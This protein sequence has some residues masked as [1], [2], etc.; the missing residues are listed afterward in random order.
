MRT[1]LYGFVCCGIGLLWAWGAEAQTDSAAANNAAGRPAAQQTAQQQRT[2]QQI[3]LL[4][5]NAIQQLDQIV[6]GE[7]PEGSEIAAGLRTVV[8]MFSR[9]ELEPARSKLDEL[10]AANPTIPPAGLLWSALLLAFNQFDAAY[11]E[12][13]KT[14]VVT[15]E[16]PGV[17][18]AFARLA[19]GRGRLADASA[20]M[21]EARRT[22]DGGTWSEEQRKHF[23]LDFL[24]TCADIASR[25][26]QFDLARAHWG[27]LRKLLPDNSLI[28]IR[29]ADLDFREQKIDSALQQ[30]TVAR[31]M[32]PENVIVPELTLFQWFQRQ[33]KADE[34]RKWID[35]AVA[36]HAEDRAVQLEYSKF[37]L[38]I[39]NPTDAAVW[40]EKAEKNG[41]ESHTARFLR[42]QIAYFRGAF[43]AAEADFKE[44]NTQRPTDF[45][46]KNML[47]LCLIESSEP[48]RKQ[49][50]LELAN[51]NLQSNPNNVYAASTLAW[52]SY[53]LGNVKQAEQ[54]F[55]QVINSPNVP[56]D[57]AFYMAHLFADEG[58][59]EQALGLLKQA[60]AAPGLFLNRQRAQ[61]FQAEIEKRLQ[62]TAPATGAVS[63]QGG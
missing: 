53:R 47:A 39:G 25:R 13:E 27:E 63:G 37:L 30:L 45:V 46:T 7:F 55:S 2:E 50:A 16:Y 10:C 8:E 56:T 5:E 26:D 1:I 15:P 20:Q 3:K 40:L 42:G 22:I 38:E 58:R 49:N 36:T 44:L 28:L 57:S 24:D 48:A 32:D 12:L 35:Q 33:G 60:L 51:F 59:Y 34:A 11:A 6:P 52:I 23:E 29:L 41:A 21:K 19:I 4:V 61:E 54:L 14:A 17:P 62:Q 31:T 18:I 9:R 43:Q